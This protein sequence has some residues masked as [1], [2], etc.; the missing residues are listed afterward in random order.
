M[1]WPQMWG[2]LG[3]GLGRIWRIGSLEVVGGL[4][5]YGFGDDVGSEEEGSE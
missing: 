5:K 1:V 2:P 4:G 3:R